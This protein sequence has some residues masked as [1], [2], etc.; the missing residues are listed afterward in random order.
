MGAYEGPP[1]FGD[2]NL[3][4]VFN[5]ADLNVMVDWLVGR[6]PMPELGTLAFIVS[7]VNGDG[8]LN[9]ADLDLYVDHLLQRIDW[10]PVEDPC[11][12]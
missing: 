9:Q 7:D 3:D 11:N 10:F 6:E 1:L 5:M 12:P 2:S 8:V 4:G